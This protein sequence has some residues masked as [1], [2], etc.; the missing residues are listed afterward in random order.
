L[1]IPTSDSKIGAM[2]D[3]E[4]RQRNPYAL[5]EPDWHLRLF[6][7]ANE[8]AHDLLALIDMDG[9]YVYASPNLCRQAGYAE[10]D[11]SALHLSDIDI[12]F[13][14][15]RLRG[16][17]SALHHDATPTFES[18]FRRKDG[19]TF[20]V[21][22]SAT[23]IAFDGHVFICAIARD[24]TER[25]NHE[26]VQREGATTLLWAQRCARAGIWDID[27]VANRIYWSEPYYE[28]YGLAPEI[29]PS[30]ENWIASIHPEDRD[31]VEREFS[32]ALQ[33]GGDQSI[34]FR[35]IR[36]GE[37]RWLR[38]EGRLVCDHDNRPARVAGIT[39]DITERKQT[40]AALQESLA[41]ESER[42]AELKTL[43]DTAPIGLA[44][45]VDRDGRHIEGNRTAEMLFDLLPGAELSKRGLQAARF[46]PVH[47]GRE[48]AVGELPMQRA[49]RGEIVDGQ[50]L[51]VVC[52]D[53]KTV[54]I[55]AK[56]TPLF[57]E[58][59]EPRGAV[60]A[61][62]D[63]TALKQAES[64]LR[65]AHDTFRHL[66]EY[67]PFGIY[68]IDADFRLVEVSAGA[69]KVFANVQPLLQRDFAHILRTLW[70]EPFATQAI[71]EF[72]RTLA[73]G[74][75]YHSPSTVEQ[76][77]DIEQ[78]EAYDWKI[79][80]I[81]LPDGRYG[82]VCHFYDLSERQRYEAQLRE[83]EERFRAV[84]EHAGTGIAITDLDGH[85]EQCNPAFCRLLGYA[86]N[87]LLETVFS[88]LVHPE[89]RSANL[90]EI[91]RLL[92]AQVPYFEI[93]NR[94]VHKDGSTVWVHKFVSLLPDVRG[95][96]A[97]LMALVTD[98]TERRH[99]E[100]MLRTAD[101]RK[102]EFLATLAHEL[103][104]PLAPISNA[105]HMLRSHGLE[106][107]HA[108]ELFAML[109]RQVNHL[110]RLVNDTL[111]VSRITRGKIA[112]KKE[113]LDLAEIIRQSIETSQPL[114][115]AGKHV[116]HVALPAEPLI[117]LADAVRLTQVFTNLLNNA[118]K[119]TP[120]HGHV[121]VIVER[122][123]NS[124]IVSV[125]DT[126]CGISAEMLPRV[127][128]L[129]AQADNSLQRTHGGLGIGLTLVR[130]LVAMHGGKVHAYSKGRNQ[131]SKFVVQLP[132][133]DCQPPETALEPLAVDA[134]KVGRRILVT[135]DNRDAADSIAWLL[136]AEGHQ[137][138]IAYDGQTALNLCA[139][140]RPEIMLLDLGMPGL[141][142]LETARR[143]RRLPE[144]HKIILIAVTGWGQED[145]RRRTTEAGFDRHFV[146]PIDLQLLR[147]FLS[148]DHPLAG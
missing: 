93:E 95:V 8:H 131:G 120:E 122:E 88:D 86:E 69:Q 30:H 22:V 137:V 9:H 71:T 109:E 46:R 136:R 129:F 24:I 77:R 17:A 58:A 10:P 145:D 53:G 37:V 56:A 92:D 111:E 54:S 76:R 33:R 78:T 99:T 12:E 94:Y 141:D 89:D 39:S 144:G 101:R 45:S 63:I 85:F 2:D 91:H 61:F 26:S 140:F 34:E 32:E 64:A 75:P 60:G 82:V 125:Q 40:E 103:R 127:F 123:Q 98:V 81:T 116:L 3:H 100:Q 138:Q 90:A 102:D 21:E 42:S 13:D 96:S 1:T 112:L 68:V 11:F 121:D 79:E 18:T 43:L 28:L 135:D 29:K 105:L 119:F 19:S 132:L 73:T 84:F 117:L 48:L 14:L 23:R 139:S 108:M 106:Q 72:R 49:V 115:K 107:V 67:S 16:L 97:H 35:I 6:Q 104:N 126:G 146:K 4:K 142:G 130:Y 36:R 38:S 31:R 134:R 147:P 62:L 110:N 52:E 47:E 83:R 59:G 70:P 118:A 51:D 27:L 25:R 41:R 87:E 50:M 55:F 148:E 143:I 20:P 133:T 74:E 124:A 80:R 114:L 65:A 7:H 128:D 66:V 44:I 5:R 113:R 15:A 57:D